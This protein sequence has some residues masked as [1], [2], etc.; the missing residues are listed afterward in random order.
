MLILLCQHNVYMLV[1]FG[2][3]NIKFLSDSQAKIVENIILKETSV[4]GDTLKVREFGST[5]G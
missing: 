3:I 4:N 5:I 2:C 1:N